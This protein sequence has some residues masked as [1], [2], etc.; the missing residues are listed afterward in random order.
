MVFVPTATIIDYINELI[1]TSANAN[2]RDFAMEL[3]NRFY[4]NIDISFMDEFLEMSSQENE[5]RFIVHHDQLKKYGIATSER[6]SAIK[7][8]LESLGLT[9]NEDWVLQDILQNSS[10]G[11]RPLK[12]Y[13]LTPEAFFLALQRAKRSANQEVDPV[14]YARYFQFLQKV[15]RYYSEYQARAEAHR[16]AMLT[17]ENITLIE[18]IDKQTAKI[19]KQTAK[20][21]KQTA[22]ID[23]QTAKIDKQTAK[24]DE[25]STE[26]AELKT[27][28]NQLIVYTK[29][30]N[31]KIDSIFDFIRR[32]AKMA[33]PMWS[34][35]SVFKTQLDNFLVSNTIDYAL[36]HL[37]VMYVIVFFGYNDE[38][39]SQTI[40]YISNTN[41]ADVGARIKTL[42]TRHRDNAFMLHPE[43]V[44][45]I[46][47]EINSEIVALDRLIPQIF[48]EE[49]IDNTV[50]ERRTKSYITT[51]VDIN[52]VEDL[53]EQ[54]VQKIRS[55]RFQGYQQRMDEMISSGTCELNP[56]IT[57][58]LLN[59]DTRF[60]GDAMPFCREYINECVIKRVPTNAPFANYEYLTPSRKTVPREEFDGKRMTKQ[61]YALNRL[62]TIIDSDDGTAIIE[63]MVDDGVI[64][65]K[66]ISVLKKIAEVENVDTSEIVIPETSSEEADDDMPPLLTDEAPAV[67]DDDMPP[68]L[69]DDEGN[70]SGYDTE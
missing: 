2:L 49:V 23:K 43:A 11:G 44:S 20:I 3:H 67:V 21:D 66:D 18:K 40:T 61:M 25:Q 45:L 29:D 1:A 17:A 5:N 48:P 58:A 31:A 6:S 26:I 69:T 33:L 7:D 30:C 4:Q 15:V 56:L 55:V 59:D 63:N 32:L 60:F 70:D 38:D 65:K 41:F 37:K 57:D 42:Y 19:D 68:L 51:G 22:K 34:G 47:C 13:Y 8:R 39:V 62:K 46:S 54:I 14:I 52:D 64:T 9:E 36:K 53:Y 27:I 24:I 28:A 16:V 50:F 10:K 35:S 12:V